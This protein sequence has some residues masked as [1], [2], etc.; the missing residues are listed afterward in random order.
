M[1]TELQKASQLRKNGDYKQAVSLY[2]TLWNNQSEQ[3]SDWDGWSYA[4]SLVKT[5]KYHEA[6]DICRHFY[7]KNKN[8]EILNNL[9][10]QCIYYTQFTGEKQPTLNVL[11]KAAQA[12][13]DLSPYSSKYSFTPKAIFKLNHALMSQKEINWAE[14]ETWLLKMDPDLLDNQPF[15]MVINKIL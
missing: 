15:K 2:D 11:R 1:N 6:L 3:W 12:M 14:I 13:L 10:A 5:F 8:F 9:Y 4:Y 7:R